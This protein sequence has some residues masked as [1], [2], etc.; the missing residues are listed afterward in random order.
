MQPQSYIECVLAHCP[1]E[2][3]PH[4]NEEVIKKWDDE[5]MMIVLLDIANEH[6]L[7][8]YMTNDDWRSY[9]FRYASSLPEPCYNALKWADCSK[10]QYSRG[11]SQWTVER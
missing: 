7:V 3:F 11:W 10:D 9:G 5:F 2:Q 8:G 4:L 1:A 6:Y